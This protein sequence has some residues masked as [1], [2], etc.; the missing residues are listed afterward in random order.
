DEIASII[1]RTPD[2]ARQLASRARRRV[3]GAQAPDPQLAGQRKVVDAFLAALRQGDFEGLLA[4][5][6]PDVVVRGAPGA[7]RAGGP[8]EIRGARTWAKGAIAFAHMV[9]FAG[10]AIVDGKIGLVVARGGHLFRALQF[11]IVGDKIVGVDVLV[12]AEQVQSLDV[13]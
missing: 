13:Q 8:T 11:T 10:P 1:G 9:R 12:S 3:R 7:G 4:V 2:A 6:D 5:L